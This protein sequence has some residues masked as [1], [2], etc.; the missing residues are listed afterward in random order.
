MI[1]C[2]VDW[3]SAIAAVKSFK[4]VVVHLFYFS[5]NSGSYL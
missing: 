5:L 3:H 2:F 4:D 1:L